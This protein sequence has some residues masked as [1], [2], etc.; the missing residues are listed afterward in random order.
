MPLDIN[1]VVPKTILK[2]YL[3]NYPRTTRWELVEAFSR[4]HHFGMNF[5]WWCK[6]KEEIASDK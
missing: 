1:E 5:G 6:V 3:K 4:V 2:F